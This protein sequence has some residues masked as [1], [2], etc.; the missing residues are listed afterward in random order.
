MNDNF[1]YYVFF[2][3]YFSKTWSHH[4]NKHITD[5]VS[6]KILLCINHVIIFMHTI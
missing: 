1:L 6:K 4:E 3:F 5:N 2:E